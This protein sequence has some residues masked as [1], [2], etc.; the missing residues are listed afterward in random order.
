MWNLDKYSDRVAV[1]EESGRTV[2]YSE[3]SQKA[4]EIKRVISKRCLCLI[5]CKNSTGAIASYTSC[6]LQGSV[7][8]LVKEDLELGL[9]SRIIKA[10]RPSYLFVPKSRLLSLNN[11]DVLFDI[12]DYVLVQTEYASEADYK[13]HPDLCQLLTTS[14]S[15]GSPKFVRQSYKNVESNSRSICEYLKLNENERPITV[16]PLY[17]TYGLSVIN[18]HLMVG[19][20]ILLT[21]KSIMQKEFWNFLKEYRATSISG[22]PYTYEMLN[23]LRFVRMELP[24][25]K[26]LTQAGGHLSP[27]LQELFA[28]YCLDNGKEFFVMYGQCEATARMSYLSPDVCLSHLGSIG[29]AIPDGSFEIRDESGLVVTESHK[30]GELIYKGPNVCMGYAC[31]Y[32]DLCLEDENNGVLNTGDLAFFDDDGYFYLSGR[33]KRFLKIFGNRLNLEELDEM[34][35]EQFP[36]IEFASWGID[37]HLYLFVSNQTMLNPVRDYVV[38]KTGLNQL[39]FKAVL[40]DRLPRNSSGK[41]L[42]RELEAYVKKEL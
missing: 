13:I 4:S 36:D 41:I 26:T 6:I 27:K 14:G 19:A 33:K 21:D 24:Y 30:E 18:T 7:P 32:S 2:T 31:G 1:I 42:Y 40:L 37:D 12:F 34:V 38:L 15:T 9:L 16:L 29:K 17:Y 8:M 11:A 5:L 23:M 3:L 20:S 10:Y 22:V 25:L 39:A 35:R 28:K